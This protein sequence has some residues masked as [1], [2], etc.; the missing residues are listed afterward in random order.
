MYRTA[1]ANIVHC[2]GQAIAL[3]HGPGAVSTRCQGAGPW[4]WVGVDGSIEPSKDAY[5]LHLVRLQAL[6][7]HGMKGTRNEEKRQV[8]G[9]RPPCV[10]LSLQPVLQAGEGEKQ[11]SRAFD[12][13]SSQME[14]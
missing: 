13:V 4:P 2:T 11:I 5:S 14:K 12:E 10:L 9:P 1:V 3:G 8:I 6:R 7:S